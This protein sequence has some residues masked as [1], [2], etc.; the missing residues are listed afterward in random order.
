MLASDGL[1]DALSSD[2]AAS[3]VNARRLFR[4]SDDAVAVAR[5]LADRAAALG[6]TDDISVAVVFLDRG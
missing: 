5:S 3:F 6:S 2:D 1:W 4:P